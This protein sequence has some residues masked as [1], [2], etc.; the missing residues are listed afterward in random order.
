MNP[1][2]RQPFDDAWRDALA[3]AE[4]APAPHVWASVEG[5]LN[6]AE[7]QRHKKRAVFYQR[8]AAAI[9]L[10]S[11]AAGV[12][13][14][15][16]WPAEE[17]EVA[18]QVSPASG[19]GL[20]SENAMTPMDERATSKS[21]DGATDSESN[22]HAR[23]DAPGG[24]TAIRSARQS[25]TSQRFTSRQKSSVRSDS[26]AL[27]ASNGE[28]E[29]NTRPT[30]VATNVNETNASDTPTASHIISGSIASPAAPAD[31]AMASKGLTPEEEQALVRQ[32]LGEEPTEEEPKERKITRGAWASVGASGGSYSPGA[33]PPN[34]PPVANML[35]PGGA[36]L[37]NERAAQGT[38][39]TVGFAFGKP[40]GSRWMLQAGVSYVNQ[41]IDYTSNVTAV[42]FSNTAMAFASD[43]SRLEN[44]AALQLTTPYIINS[45]SEFVSVP[46]QVGYRVVRKKIGVLLNTGV[47]TDFFVRNSLVDQSG[48]AETVRQ[49]AG[50]ESAYRSVTWSGLG[51]VEV[52]YQLAERYWLALVPG[53]RYS[54]SNVTRAETTVYQ[55]LVLDVGF[56]F[57]YQFN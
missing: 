45:T 26:H 14:Y 52:S 15:Q 47:A 10:M 28:T 30:E 41:Q 11:L 33:A 20:A 50:S 16:R 48:R 6:A 34:T 43:A 12:T 5:A 35:S 4:L 25:L 44:V 49:S 42:G 27:M 37:E 46:V 18:Q 40:V 1:T 17:A 13:V 57:R 21:P 9:L 19:T 7:N 23:H 22:D 36:A 51:N 8:M 53:V 24:S 31:S 2:E 32:L 29:P 3:G 38:S 55:P 56:R 39:Y 54:L